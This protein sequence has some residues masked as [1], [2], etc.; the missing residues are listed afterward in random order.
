MKKTIY[1][2]KKKY[3]LIIRK[4]YDDKFLVQLYTVANKK[5]VM[6]IYGTY[7]SWLDIDKGLRGKEKP[8]PWQGSVKYDLREPF[9]IY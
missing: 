1:K 5:K 2:K 3:T 9:K 8:D 4:V 6:K 7:D